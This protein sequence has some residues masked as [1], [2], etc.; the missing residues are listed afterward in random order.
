MKRSQSDV[1][2]H[3]RG[4][5]RFI[6]TAAMTAVA[7]YI[8]PST[9]FGSSAPSNQIIMGCIGTGFQWGIDTSAFMALDDV[10]IVS[11]C[12]VDISRRKH[13]KYSIS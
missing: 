3:Y 11:V 5:R 12:D 13:A 7:P 4:R 1:K 9:V 6:Q 10:R 2:P 8:V